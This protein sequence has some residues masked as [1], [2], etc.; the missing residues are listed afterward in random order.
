MCRNF[1][2]FNRMSD[3]KEYENRVRKDKEEVVD[4]GVSVDKV[5]VSSWLYKKLELFS[6]LFDE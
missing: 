2:Y 4:S 1:W 5:D 6:Y 3:L